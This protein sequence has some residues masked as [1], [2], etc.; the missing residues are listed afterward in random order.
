MG[1]PVNRSVPRFYNDL[2]RSIRERGERVR[3]MR[4][5]L[6]DGDVTPEQRQRLTAEL[7]GLRIEND[8][9]AII[10]RQQQ[11]SID[12]PA[13]QAGAN[14]PDDSEL[15]DVLARASDM[16]VSSNNTGIDIDR[17]DFFGHESLAEAVDRVLN[18]VNSEELVAWCRDC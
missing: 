18:S 6:L 2:V 17:A 8:R 12:I 3:Q 16:S 15:L 4:A 7:T 10:L 13:A 9:D 1:E 5:L 14:A 11:D